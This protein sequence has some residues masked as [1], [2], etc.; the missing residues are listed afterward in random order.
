M[1][2]LH[3]GPPQGEVAREKREILGFP[4]L[5]KS[6]EPLAQVIREYFFFSQSF[7]CMW[8]CC[9]PT[10]AGSW[11]GLIS[12]KSTV[13]SERKKL[14]FP[15]LPSVLQDTPFLVLWPERQ[16]FSESLSCFHLLQ[17]SRMWAVLEFNLEMWRKTNKPTNQGT[18]SY[19]NYSL[20]FDF[21]P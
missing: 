4:T 2:F 6:Q 16:G 8:D 9:H 12:R 7:R 13:K 20:S 17:N 15:L 11:L 18:H 3:L 10:T 21:P 14:G 5:F 19:F 1:H